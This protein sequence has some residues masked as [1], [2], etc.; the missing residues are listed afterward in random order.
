MDPRQPPAV[1]PVWARWGACGRAATDQTSDRAA[2]DDRSG[3]DLRTTARTAPAGADRGRCAS[4]K[5][6][7]RHRGRDRCSAVSDQAPRGSQFRRLSAP[8]RPGGRGAGDICRQSNS[9]IDRLVDVFSIGSSVTTQV[10]ATRAVTRPAVTQ[11]LRRGGSRRR[12]RRA[13]AL[14]GRRTSRGH[15]PHLLGSASSSRWRPVSGTSARRTGTCQG[16]LSSFHRPGFPRFV[17][18]RRP[19]RVRRRKSKPAGPELPS[20]SRSV[21]ERASPPPT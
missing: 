6:I 13:A 20:P 8:R 15:A 9:T 10:W 4:R 21:R 14:P 17:R 1:L 12:R 7:G 16:P 11:R 19:D 3:R 18:H 5:H 2:R